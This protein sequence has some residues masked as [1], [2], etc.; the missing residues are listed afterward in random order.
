MNIIEK[1]NIFEFFPEN[2]GNINITSSFM[3]N[4]IWFLHL[5]YILVIY[6]TSSLILFLW[7]Q[8]LHKKKK[9]S[10]DARH[11]SHRGGAGE[12]LENTIGAF[13]RAIQN[14]TDMLE[15]DVHI[16]LDEK[17]VV[18]HENYLYRLTGHKVKISDTI[19]KN[20]PLLKTKIAIDNHANHITVSKP[21]EDRQIPQLEEIFI[22]FPNI[23]MNIDIKYDSIPLIKKVQELL[24][25]YDRKHLTILGSGNDKIASKI[26]SQRD[27]HYFFSENQMVL[28]VI[29][30]YLGLLMYMPITEIS[31][32]IPVPKVLLRKGHYLHNCSFIR[33]IMVLL[34]DKLI[35]NSFFVNY[36]RRRG[37]HTY[38]W[39][40]NE[41]EDWNRIHNLKVPVGI[42]TDFPKKLNEYICKNQK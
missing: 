37:I 17:V 29:Y 5:L 23:P 4:S 21:N 33:R 15:L 1:I 28:Y 34:F 11:I 24:R 39:V 18:V 6:F 31:C 25:V 12:S 36:L 26:K 3:Y 16:T 2:I 7:P 9:L 30:F 22:A 35:V 8:L 40:L 19:Y 14:G 38:F 32:E 41:E 42:M 27:F 20:L 10:F 13:K